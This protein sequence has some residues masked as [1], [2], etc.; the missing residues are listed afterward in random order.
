MSNVST[1][2]VVALYQII[3]EPL[4]ADLQVKPSLKASVVL[5]EEYSLPLSIGVSGHTIHELFMGNTSNNQPG[6]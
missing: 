4:P 2:V 1:D 3:L 5:L 6:K